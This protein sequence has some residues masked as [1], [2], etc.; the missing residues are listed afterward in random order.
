MAIYNM[1][2]NHSQKVTVRV[3]GLAAS[4]ASVIAMAGDEIQIARAGFLMIHNAWV[5][6]IGNR[7]DM[8]EVA[9]FLEPFDAAM[10]DVY[11]A[12]AGVDNAAAMMDAEKWIGGSEAVS[13]GFA[14]ALLDADF[15][16]D[17]PEARAAAKDML[18]VRIVDA[19]LARAGTPR[20]ERRS[21]IAGLKGGTHDAAPTA[22]LDAG[23][24]AAGLRL[25]NTIKI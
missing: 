6:A 11:Q 15:I 4:A 24:M 7:H 20:S 14:D 25:L 13:M 21:L 9:D 1:L 5:V 18:A 12:R 17:D 10:A 23:A 2:R 22:T 16:A 8:R 3:L 19:K